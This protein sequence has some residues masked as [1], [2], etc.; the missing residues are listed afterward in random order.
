MRKLVLPVLVLV[1]VAVAAGTF[2]SMQER[3]YEAEVE[4]GI[5]LLDE[6]APA[7]WIG[8]V[9]IERLDMGSGRNCILGQVFGNYSWGLSALRTTMEG[10]PSWKF[11][12]NLYF[13]SVFELGNWSALT[14][15]WKRALRKS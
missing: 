7:D 15:E 1:V 9:D 11:G 2:F 8:N 4:R 6:H 14:E 10:E 3:P 5:A 12:F 13:K